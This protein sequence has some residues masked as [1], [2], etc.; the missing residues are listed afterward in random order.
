MDRQHFYQIPTPIDRHPYLQWHVDPRLRRY[1]YQRIPDDLAGSQVVGIAQIL[2]V[3]LCELSSLDLPSYTPAQRCL[4]GC[5][6]ALLAQTLFL[7]RGIGSKVHSQ[8]RR[9]IFEPLKFHCQEVELSDIYQTGSIVICHPAQFLRNFQPDRLDWYQSFTT[10]SYY[11]FRQSL[12]DRLRTLPNATDFKRTN[13]GLLYRSSIE[14]ALREHERE[15]SRFEGLLLLHQC[16]REAVIAKQFVTNNPQLNHYDALLARYR[17]QP[18]SVQLAIVDR[19]MAIELLQYLG[20]ILRNYKQIGT[21]SLDI[22]VGEPDSGTNFGDLQAAP[23]V[24]GT[25]EDCETRE[26]A[27]QLFDRQPPNCIFLLVFGLDLDQTEAGIELGVH[28]TTIGRQSKREISKLAQEFHLDRTPVESERE[29]SAEI[30]AKYINYLT[31]VCENYYPTLLADLLAEIIEEDR[32]ESRIMSVFI[33]RI[34]TQWQFKFKPDGVG[35]QKI[36]AF[37]QQHQQIGK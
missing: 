20:N 25:S 31:W 6:T 27:I 9:Q 5:I 19:A 33:D 17:S 2:V 29:L 32:I 28:Q 18:A 24:S 7:S 12:I 14:A 10:Y 8:I 23:Q 1:I 16:F 22:P 13:L 37:I 34:E 30:L 3:E 4:S 35:L 36:A 21:Y 11:K 15:G 26:R